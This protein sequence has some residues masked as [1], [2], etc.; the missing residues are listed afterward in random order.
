MTLI[1]ITRGTTSGRAA[2][3]ALEPVA[4]QAKDVPDAMMAD[5]PSATRE[6]RVNGGVSA[7]NLFMPF[8]PGILDVS[9]VR[10][11]TLETIAMGPGS[12]PVWL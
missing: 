4:C 11:K 5:S 6:V 8:Q 2:R 12:L 1:G 10:P 9:V 7:N 3:A